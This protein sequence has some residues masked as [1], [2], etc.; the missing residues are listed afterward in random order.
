[1]NQNKAIGLLVLIII[2]AALIA[3]ARA[4]LEGVAWTFWSFVPGSRPLNNIHPWD[5]LAMAIIVICAIGFMWK[6]QKK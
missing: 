6:Y 2:V 3:Y 1:M 4:V 5:Y